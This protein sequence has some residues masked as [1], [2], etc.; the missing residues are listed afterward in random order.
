M[1][2]TNTNKELF[3]MG[4]IQIK[5]TEA[6]LKNLKLKKHSYFA[7]D[8][9]SHG[10]AIRVYPS[11]GKTFYFVY[12]PKNNS[13]T[14]QIS[15]GKFGKLTITEARAK[16]LSYMRNMRPMITYPRTNIGV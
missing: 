4:Q 16:A 5:F 10:L 14:Q 9:K 1:I 11:G 6:E 13:S 2:V 12:T 7:Y 8:I 3:D 15:L